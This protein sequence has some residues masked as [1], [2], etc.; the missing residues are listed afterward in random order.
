[1]DFPVQI[2][3]QVFKNKDGS[4]GE[5][6]LITNDLQLSFQD[7]TTTDEE[8]WGVEMLHKSLK[9]NV[10]LEK[11]PTKN[12]VTQSNHIF[13]AMIPNSTLRLSRLLSHL[14]IVLLII[15]FKFCFFTIT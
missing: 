13:A 1:M 5:L 10:G 8:R 2:C 4:T 6:Y 3:R 11:S 7:I 9:Q 15:A 14:V 12:E